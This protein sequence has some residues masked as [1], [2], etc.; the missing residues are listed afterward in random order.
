MKTNSFTFRIF[1]DV[2]LVVSILFFPWWTTSVF[3]LFGVFI[4][5]NYVE[6][7]IAGILVDVLYGQHTAMVSFSGIYGTASTIVI[8]FAIKL[9]KSKLR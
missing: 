6:I 9:L 5:P 1:F 8:Y 3:V 2:F 4:F 7:I